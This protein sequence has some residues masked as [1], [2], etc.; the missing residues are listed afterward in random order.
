MLESHSPERAVA[1]RG[2]DFS[3][4]RVSE[5]GQPILPGRFRIK[6]PIIALFEENGRHVARMVPAGAVVTIDGPAFDG[7]KLVNVIWDRRDVMMFTQDLETRAKPVDGIST[8]AIA[9]GTTPP[10]GKHPA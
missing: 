6:E 8:S 4:D 1:R 5:R 3:F 2:S 7:D 10:D 9:G